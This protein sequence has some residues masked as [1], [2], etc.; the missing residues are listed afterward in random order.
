MQIR[1]ADFVRMSG[2]IGL[3]S[4]CRFLP[5]FSAEHIG[6]YIAPLGCTAF[7]LQSQTHLNMRLVFAVWVILWILAQTL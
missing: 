6:N 3:S 2:S 7:G 1:S 5:L 4:L